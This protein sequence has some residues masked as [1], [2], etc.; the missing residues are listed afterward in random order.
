MSNDFKFSAGG[1]PLRVRPQ[2]LLG[3][4]AG[5]LVM[6]SPGARAQ[7]AADLKYGLYIHFGMDTFRHAGEKGEL[8]VARFA[9]V[10]VDVQQWARTA[11][12]AGMTFAVLTAKHETGFCLWDSQDNDY[13]IAQSPYR[14]DLLADFIAAC[15][16]EG[17]VPGVHYS[18]PDNHNEG[19]VHF[20]GP[21]PPPYF[22]VIRQHFTELCTKY[23]DLRIIIPNGTPRLSPAQLEELQQIVHRLNPQCA[24]WPTQKGGT[25][26]PH[27][28]S[29]TVNKNWMWSPNETLS[30]APGLFKTYQQCR[31]AG[32]AFVLNVGPGPDGEIPA[33]QIAVLRQLKELI[34]NPPVVTETATPDAKPDAAARLKNLKS[35]HDQGL[36]N[37]EDYDRK[38]KEIMDSL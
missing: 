31:A 30:P 28:E 34:A 6:V 35:L 32:K 5:L 1:R 22:K 36:I 26:G 2:T 13:D 9:P 11:K 17:L 18:I 37:Q 8:P 20:N 27:H 7:A 25:V 10:R 23:P 16:A 33:N 24:V 4:L 19:G 12:E 29:A 15:Q 14:R 38:V 3:W 21:V